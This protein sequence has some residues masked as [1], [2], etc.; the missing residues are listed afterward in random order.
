MSEGFAIAI[1]AR[2]WVKGVVVRME[3]TRNGRCLIANL[4]LTVTSTSN[5]CMY[6]KRQ[7]VLLTCRP[8]LLYLCHDSNPPLWIKVITDQ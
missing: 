7:I 2:F 4:F 3:G 6:V 8:K 5:Y 1:V